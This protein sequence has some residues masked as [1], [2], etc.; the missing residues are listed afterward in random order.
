M[1]SVYRDA[2]IEI[3]IVECNKSRLTV[4]VRYNEFQKFNDAL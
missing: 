1:Q 3:I 2:L 4:V